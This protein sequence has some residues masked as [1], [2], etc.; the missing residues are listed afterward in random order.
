MAS[1]V[2]YN[3]ILRD[4]LNRKIRNIG[5]SPVCNLPRLLVA[6]HDLLKYT[7]ILEGPFWPH[8]AILA[9]QNRGRFGSN[10]GQNRTLGAKTER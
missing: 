6:E 9:F 2:N 10:R 5:R 1:V 7:V 3:I 4:A 8:R